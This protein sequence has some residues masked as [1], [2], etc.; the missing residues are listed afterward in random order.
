MPKPIRDLLRL[1]PILFGIAVALASFVA[2]NRLDG[3]VPINEDGARDQLLARDCADLGR[4]HLTGPATSLSG[5]RQGAAWLDLLV[6]IR[7]LGGDTSTDRRVV[8]MLLALSVATVFVVVWRW[9]RPSVA[10]PAAVGMLAGLSIDQYPSLL[11]NPCTSAFADVLTAAGIL[12]Y[13]LSGQRRFLMLATVAFGVAINLHIGSVAL[14]PALAAVPGLVQRR[15]WR[16]VL[17]A[18]TVA[19][20]VCV[21][22]SRVAFAANVVELW[23]RGALVPALLAGL[24]LLVLSTAV[25]V[26]FRRS[27]WNARAW[28]IGLALVVPFGLASLWLVR[29]ENHHF[30]VL[31][32]HPILGPT[33][34]MFAAL[35]CV[36]FEV[37]AR[38]LRPLRWVPT[39]GSLALLS[40]YV[41]RPPVTYPQLWT[42]E[43]AHAIISN[44]E[45]HGL[46]FEDLVFRL[47]AENCWELL[48]GMSIGAA[49][50]K[51]FA[52]VTPGRHQ[53]RVTRVSDD[54]DDRSAPAILVPLRPGTVAVLRD[55]ESWMD[56]D[57]LIACRTPTDGRDEVCA[58]SIKRH[59]DE[60][61][62]ERFLLSLY[63]DTGVHGL[64]AQP[65][66][67]ARYTIP[68]V[69]S[70]G[71]SRAVGVEHNDR[72][73]DSDTP[74]CGWRITRVDGVDADRSLPA[75]QVRL[76][77]A[78]GARG[79][80][81]VEKPFGTA[82]CRG[83]GDIDRNYPPCIFESSD[84]FPSD[85][86]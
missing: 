20:L 2:L 37:A 48:T 58:P 6:A 64:D 52:P 15:P 50:P 36:P 49:P 3:A 82:A 70:A 17:A 60:M 66:Y 56:T 39:V 73:H 72:L 74:D 67:V 57:N 65:P 12:C 69:P 40:T 81:V 34:T 54:R 14:A 43:D 76:H 23:N 11:T 45:N 71:A 38:W 25:G 42:V 79:L 44:A 28:A 22:T 29:A 19:F 1:A 27:S 7:V 84:Q 47:Q 61:T 30:D 86:S 26:R 5:F 16:D 63:S 18:A 31:Y 4:C 62:P 78:S 13:G 53:L 85:D 68:L 32:L 59:A 46:A 55:I 33:A 35:V 80:L 51:S 83:N 41:S 8:L 24:L 77:S 75:R 21:A 10:L 9:L